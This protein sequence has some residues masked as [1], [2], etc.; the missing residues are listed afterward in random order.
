ML[1]K[2]PL[3]LALAL[4]VT[5]VAASRHRIRSTLPAVAVGL[6]LS[7]SLCIHLG[8]D[9]PAVRSLRAYHLRQSEVLAE[10]LPNH[11]ALFAFG[12]VKD[13]AGPLLLVRD[14]VILD[15]MLDAGEDAPGQA[16]ALLA[17]G[18]RVFVDLARMP[19]EVFERLREG[20]EV[21]VRVPGQDPI[22]ELSH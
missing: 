5:F 17:A 22:I 13:S 10:I 7:W 11:S 4:A 9:L 8:D 19:E 12:P 6:C 15:P 20:L 21:Q 1:L 2:L 16:R 3:V 18:R 14:L